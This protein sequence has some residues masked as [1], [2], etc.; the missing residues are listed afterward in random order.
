MNYPG[1]FPFN[2]FGVRTLFFPNQKF[3]RNPSSQTETDTH[4]D[5]KCYGIGPPLCFASSKVRPKKLQELENINNFRFPCN[6]EKDQRQFNWS[7]SDPK[8]LISVEKT[9]PQRQTRKV[10]TTAVTSKLSVARY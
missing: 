4:T 5:R 7:W 1:P 10:K 6:L 8:Q 9:R 2:F 3:S